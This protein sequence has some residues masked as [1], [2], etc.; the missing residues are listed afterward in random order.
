MRHSLDKQK[1]L[2]KSL[3]VPEFKSGC[4]NEAGE[5]FHCWS[6]YHETA[7]TEP[8]ICFRNSEYIGR[9]SYISYVIFVS[10]EN[11]KLSTGVNTQRFL[12]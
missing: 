2:W 10:G 6:H 8:S 4:R 9:V 3:K 11:G 12:Y 5:L 1:C 7:I